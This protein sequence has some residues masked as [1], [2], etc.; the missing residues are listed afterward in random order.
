[1]VAL[2]WTSGVVVLKKTYT[3]LDLLQTA[4]LHSLQEDYR[5]KHLHVTRY[6]RA[7]TVS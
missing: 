2:Q 1:M 5:K 7:V 6:G 4:T 3:T